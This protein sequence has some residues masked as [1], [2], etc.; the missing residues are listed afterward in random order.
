MTN[1]DVVDFEHYPRCRLAIR[2]GRRTLLTMLSTELR[3]RA[4][5]DRGGAAYRLSD[6]GLMADDLLE[7]LVPAL[8]PGT[9]LEESAG[10]IR[11]RLAGESASIVLA[12]L[13]GVAASVIREADGRTPLWRIARE[14]S[15]PDH[16]R[17]FDSRALVRG[18]FLHLVTLGVWAPSQPGG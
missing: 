2:I 18:V 4:D 15:V 10:W 17:P 12:S 7:L 9:H 13:S 1:E 11:A 14:I 8:T 3:V 6:L 16:G 5:V